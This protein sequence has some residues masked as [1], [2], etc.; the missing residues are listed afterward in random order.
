MYFSSFFPQPFA[1]FFPSFFK[2]SELIKKFGFTTHQENTGI[3]ELRA[4]H[5][6]KSL[7][8]LTHLKPRPTVCS[9]KLSYFLLPTPT[10]TT[11]TP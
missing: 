11:T 3:M 8:G 5:L 4:V 2:K 10:T 9:E 6:Q 7:I 1:T